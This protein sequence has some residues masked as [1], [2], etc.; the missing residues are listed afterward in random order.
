MTTTAPPTVP[1]VR[2]LARL[3]Q[4]LA[5]YRARFAV[6]GVALLVAAGCTLAV[7]Q[8][9]KLVVDRGFAAGDG[10][11]LDR[12]L[13]AMPLIDCQQETAHL[14]RFG[15]RPIP[16]QVFAAELSRLVNSAQAAGA[17]KAAAKFESDRP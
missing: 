9:L 16:R 13:F 12:A 6:A 5:P 15:A 3:S 11:E 14:T 1:V 2:T 8:G 17:W 10:A 4:Y 7:G